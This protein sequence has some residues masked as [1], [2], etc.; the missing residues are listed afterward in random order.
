MGFRRTIPGLWQT[1]YPYFKQGRKTVSCTY[2]NHHLLGR[3]CR[4]L[5][6][7]ATSSLPEDR[8]CRGH[9]NVD[10]PRVRR[11]VRRRSDCTC[12]PHLFDTA[13]GTC[14]R[15]TVAAAS[16]RRLCGPLTA[17]TWRLHSAP[18]RRRNFSQGYSISN[19]H[20]GL[21]SVYL[22]IVNVKPHFLL[23]FEILI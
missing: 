13:Y 4:D 21:M 17:S 19:M 18:Q 3:S 1:H 2:P 8:R 10:S 12:Q 16:T 22:L 11:D 5:R 20:F 9:S 6:R 23:Y 7:T 15:S 14:S